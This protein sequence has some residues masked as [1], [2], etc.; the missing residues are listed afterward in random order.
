MGVAQPFRQEKL[1]MGVLI[2]RP[3]SLEGLLRRLERVWGRIDYQSQAVDFG[4]THY[5]DEEMGPRIER[6][7]VSFERLISPEILAAVKVQT[8]GI[9]DD[10][11]DRGRRT[12]NLDPGML[13]LGRLVLA[14]T[15]DGSHRIPLQAGIFGEVTL[16]YERGRFKPL[17]WTYPDYRSPKYGEIL[18]EIRQIYRKQMR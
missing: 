15:K 14:T 12:V 7:F 9:E 3:E 1:I 11:R 18:Q 2:S 4:F 16:V 8:N 17:E 5:Y 10:F 6:L 13:S